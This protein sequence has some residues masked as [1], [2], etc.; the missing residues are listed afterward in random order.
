[1]VARVDSRPTP[2]IS[3]RSAGTSRRAVSTTR[4]SSSSRSGASP[5]VPSATTPLNPAAIHRRIL[6]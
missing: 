5:L 6:L 1:M 4:C 2:A 3:V